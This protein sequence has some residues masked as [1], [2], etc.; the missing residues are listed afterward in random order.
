MNDP[1]FDIRLTTPLNRFFDFDPPTGLQSTESLFAALV[2]ALKIARPVLTPS[3]P[4]L[5]NR[6]E[7]KE[8]LGNW[9]DPLDHQQLATQIQNI[10]NLSWFFE[11]REYM[12]TPVAD[13]NIKLCLVRPEYKQPIMDPT[14][15]ELFLRQVHMGHE[16]INS[17]VSIAAQLHLC[18]GIIRQVSEDGKDK[19]RWNLEI[20]KPSDG[21]HRTVYLFF[22]ER[23]FDAKGSYEWIGCRRREGAKNSKAKFAQKLI[24]FEKTY[25]PAVNAA[26]TVAFLG[27]YGNYLTQANRIIR[28]ARTAKDELVEQSKD[29]SA[30]FAVMVDMS[31]K[32]VIGDRGKNISDARGAFNSGVGYADWNTKVKNADDANAAKELKKKKELGDVKIDLDTISGN[33]GESS[34][35]RA[36]NIAAIETISAK[37]SRGAV[38]SLKEQRK[39]FWEL[40]NNL[41][42]T[43]RKVRQSFVYAVYRIASGNFELSKFLTDTS[44]QVAGRILLEQYPALFLRVA[45]ANS[46]P[47]NQIL[48]EVFSR[49]FTEKI[50]MGEK[51][52]KNVIKKWS[53]MVRAGKLGEYQNKLR[54][55][56]IEYLN[57][58]IAEDNAAQPTNVSST[59]PNNSALARSRQPALALRGIEKHNHVPLIVEGENP[60]SR[61]SDMNALFYRTVTLKIAEQAYVMCLGVKPSYYTEKMRSIG[62]LTLLAP[63]L[64]LDDPRVFVAQNVPAIEQDRAPKLF[65]HS[66]FPSLLY[67]KS[68]TLQGSAKANMFGSDDKRVL[69][70]KC[71]AAIASASRLL[72][73]SGV[74][75][76]WG[77]AFQSIIKF[78]T[79]FGGEYCE[80]FGI[81]NVQYNVK[82]GSDSVMKI[83]AVRMPS[84]QILAEL[85][86]LVS[87][88]VFVWRAIMTKLRSITE[89]NKKTMYPLIKIVYNSAGGGSDLDAISHTKTIA[90][91][92]AYRNTPTMRN[93]YV[94]IERRRVLTRT[95]WHEYVGRHREASNYVRDIKSGQAQC[96]VLH[97]LALFRG[98]LSN[99][100]YK[101]KL[102]SFSK[103]DDNDDEQLLLDASG[104]FR[105]MLSSV[106]M[107][108]ESD[109]RIAL[110]PKIDTE[111]NS[112][113]FGLSEKLRDSM[114]AH[115]YGGTI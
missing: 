85:D 90:T 75:G 46:F 115:D 10:A 33:V 44:E 60:F 67:T 9:G 53:D 34:D 84:S 3:T 82:K 23:V 57:I 55:A 48:D 94:G 29:G 36:S 31:E 104:F 80:H 95:K 2:Y 6:P 99:E 98:C 79:Q 18:V 40:W 49:A 20:I 17:L 102:V 59:N 25:G 50:E 38:V 28:T 35:D 64:P 62:L 61:V 77:A 14:Y 63:R 68:L 32:T 52:N 83:E 72:I 86:S 27:V 100:I 7:Q 78:G 39:K 93:E 113:V 106:G 21:T 43:I 109:Y 11:S 56:C 5:G 45:L 74:S 16:S 69:G 114:L 81:N 26:G 42:S 97:Y 103:I 105:N 4:A 58:L 8:V 96:S 89:E 91:L 41:D 101:N 87:N 1:K 76:I 111:R 54:N 71:G 47:G 88:L 19:S 66:V 107:L 12:G 73:M 30:Q 112:G 108:D 13:R 24:E 70:E 37:I 65:L 51:K 22:H 15:Q 92:H 110:E